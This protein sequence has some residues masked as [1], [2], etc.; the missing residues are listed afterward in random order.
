M[1]VLELTGL[2]GGIRNIAKLWNEFQLVRQA[3]AVSW[4]RFRDEKDGHSYVDLFVEPIRASAYFFGHLVA[5]L[6]VVYVVGS[7]ISFTGMV[8][9]WPD[10]AYLMGIVV[11]IVVIWRWRAA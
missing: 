6:L 11:A 9:G 10:A 2:N 4:A 1:K 8:F 3:F 7:A 5:I